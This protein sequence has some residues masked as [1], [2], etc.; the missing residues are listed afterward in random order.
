MTRH[1]EPDDPPR[2]HAESLLDDA[3]DDS[4]PASDPPSMAQPHGF[5]DPQ[6]PRPAS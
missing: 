6:L 1:I 5:E 2:A 4:F 3:L